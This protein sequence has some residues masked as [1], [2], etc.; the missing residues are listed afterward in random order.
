MGDIQNTSDQ[1]ATSQWFT[2]RNARLN[3]GPTPFDQRQVFNAYWTYELPFGRGK[4]FA[5]SNGVLDRVVGG[6]TIGGRESIRTGN[7][8]LLSGGRNTV[9]NLSQSGVVL[10]SGLTVSQLQHDL[11]AITGYYAAAKGYI[12]DMASIASVTASTTSANPAF[13]APASAPGQYAQFVYLR[14]NTAFQYDM[15]LNKMVHIRERWKFNFQAEAL[16]FLN[17]PFFPLANTSPTAT[18]FGQITSAVG[19]RT[20]QLRGSLE[21]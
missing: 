19:T 13:Y 9:N 8:V 10:G 4:H 15:S 21:W 16:N 2:T 18:N 3:Y 7:P 1:T 11:T 20:M 14:N 12:T 17:H 6:W 5:V